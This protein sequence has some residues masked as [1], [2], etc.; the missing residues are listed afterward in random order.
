M[1]NTIY[2]NNSST[3][4]GLDLFTTLAHE[5]Y[6]G[7]LYQTVYYGLY[8]NQ[9]N[10]PLIRH[11]MNYEGYLE[12]WAIYCELYSYNYATKLYPIEER[13][14]YTLWHKLLLTDRKLQLA[15][16]SLL[17]IN[18]H[19]YDDSFETAKNILNLYGITDNET[20]TSIYRYVL[21]EPGNYLKYYMGYLSIMDLKEKAKTIM[22]SDFTDKKFHELI[23]NA[24]PS[25]YD[26]LEKRIMTYSSSNIDSR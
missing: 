21:E 17:D 25:D 13:T 5:G 16:L 1:K 20:I 23:L 18:L 22:G 14:F 10:I 26:N 3:P 4:Q 19:F 15:I 6:P 8:S 24:G 9:H 2:I 11:I 7:H 12:G